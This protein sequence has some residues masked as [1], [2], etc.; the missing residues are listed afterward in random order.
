VEPRPMRL[1]QTRLIWFGMI[2]SPIFYC[3]IAFIAGMQEGASPL[4]WDGV[5][6]GTP[7]VR[8]SVL[9]PACA[10]LVPVLIGAL[11]AIVVRPV[12]DGPD[13]LSGGPRDEEAVLQRWMLRNIVFFAL[14]EAVPVLAVIYVLL[15]GTAPVLW[16]VSAEYMVLMAFYFPRLPAGLSG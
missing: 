9:L 7:P 11:R 16:L 13:P 10:L 14:A 1:W 15:W 6:K 3:F 8:A 2:T 12:A 4:E 5:L